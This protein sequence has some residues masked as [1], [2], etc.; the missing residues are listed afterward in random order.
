[1]Q[2]GMPISGD[3]YV[4]Q[5]RVD[6]IT[7]GP[8]GYQLKHG[9]HFDPLEL[10]ERPPFTTESGDAEPC[11]MS[12]RAPSVFSFEDDITSGP[13]GYLLKHG[14]HF[15]PL[16]LQE[17]PPFTTESSEAQS[18]SM[19]FRAQS[20]LSSTERSF[21]P[22]GSFQHFHP[23]LESMAA[24]LASSWHSQASTPEST[25]RASPRA[26]P[27]LL[28]PSS[29]PFLIVYELKLVASTCKANLFNLTPSVHF[30]ESLS[31]Q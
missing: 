12:C 6:D 14:D 24:S 23:D 29:C 11:S 27:S 26:L 22:D 19:S 9:N 16:E 21:Q 2:P 5:L 8:T 13:T 1:M 31:M 4:V 7:S 17:L 15:D 20:D 3:S 18:C 10:Q 25:P 30:P 28:L